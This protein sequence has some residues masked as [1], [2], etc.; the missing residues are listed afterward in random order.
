MFMVLAEAVPLV[1]VGGLII[2]ATLAIWDWRRQ[3]ITEGNQ[4]VD[5]QIR[6]QAHERPETDLY[7]QMHQT[8]GGRG[9][10]EGTKGPTEQEVG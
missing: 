1:A 8:G 7:T 6:R 10:L 9:G 3:D 4:I 2:A 5:E